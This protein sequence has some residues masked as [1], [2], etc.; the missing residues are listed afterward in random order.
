[1]TITRDFGDTTA[2]RLELFKH[3]YRDL[4][5]IEAKSRR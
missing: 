4:L 1:M 5:P 3:G 2:I